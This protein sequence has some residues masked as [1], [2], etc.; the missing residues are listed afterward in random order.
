MLGSEYLMSN[1]RQNS[2]YKSCIGDNV[3]LV[4][5]ILLALLLLFISFSIIY[6]GERLTISMEYFY[7]S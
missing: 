4:K 2:S 3:P 6:L 5:I 1:G 7:F